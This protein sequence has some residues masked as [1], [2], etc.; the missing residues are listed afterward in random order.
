MRI[1]YFGFAAL[2]TATSITMPVSAQVTDGKIKIGVFTDISG[3]YQFSSG[4]ATQFAV[5]LAIEERGGKAAGAPVEVL[6]TGFGAT[7]DES[8]AKA[9]NWYEKD[10]V[11]LIIDMP[12][13]ALSMRVAK[14]AAELGK[15]HINTTAG[16]SDMTGK[17]CGPN[18]AHWTYD[19]YATG[20]GTTLPT[21]RSGGDTWFYITLDTPLGHT[22]EANSASVVTA[23]GGKVLGRALHKPGAD[24]MA[25]QIKAARDSGAKVVALANTGKDTELA[26]REA[27]R[28]GIW[29]DGQ[30][31]AGML[32]LI[33]EVHNLG[34]QAAQGLLLTESFYWDLNDSTR[35]WSAKFAER[36]K[37]VKPTMA[38]A[39]AYSA[40]LHYLKA[41][42]ALGSD[43]NGAAIIAKMKD[44]PTDDAVFGKG[45]LRADGRKIHD[46]Y[47]F[48]V[49]APRQ[50]NQ[51]W[52]Y[53]KLVQMIPG[54]QAFRPL[55][56]GGCP[57]VSSAAKN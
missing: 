12:H 18:Y 42:D 31:I 33:S 57:L 23:N 13:S 36:N 51:T 52:D 10:G 40:V 38:H 47:L 7:D 17:G 32:T 2:L 37:G 45:S 9:R 20:R 39:G 44:L 16:S 35:A 48:Q 53:Y 22:L 55:A 41:I 46:M 43:A 8:M 3:P 49:K 27:A 21:L 11:D 4:P 6:V 25:E 56:E 14:V 28:A 54:D 19:A 1:A 5:D 26:M 50:S 15:V 34:L 29:R 24:S 30:R